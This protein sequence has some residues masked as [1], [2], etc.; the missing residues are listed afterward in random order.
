MEFFSEPTKKYDHS[1]V[2]TLHKDKLF[3]CLFQFDEDLVSPFQMMI[4][5]PMTGI[6]FGLS[7]TL[8]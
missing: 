1:I 6:L 3:F 4:M 7:N 2:S 5:K 8:F